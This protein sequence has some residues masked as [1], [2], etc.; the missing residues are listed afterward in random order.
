MDRLKYAGLIECGD[1]ILN[2]ADAQNEFDG[3]QL[4]KVLV[5]EDVENNVAREFYPEAE[6]VSDTDSIMNDKTIELVIVSAPG[7]ADLTLVAKAIGAGKQVRV[8]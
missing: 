2:F 6:L 8:L 7:E 4:K 3:W 1:S 5:K